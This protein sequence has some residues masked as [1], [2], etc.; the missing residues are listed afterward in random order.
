MDL[1]SLIGVVLAFA[2]ILVGAVLKGAGIHALL[3][4]AAFMIVFMG[5]IAAIMVQTPGVAMR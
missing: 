2:A 5:T 1:L 4:S 3:S